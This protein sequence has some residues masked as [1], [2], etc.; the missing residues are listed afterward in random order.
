MKLK[1]EKEFNDKY[2][3]ETYVKGD[4]VEF[5]DS[6]AEEILADDRELASEFKEKP[7]K[8]IKK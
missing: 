2:T 4:V 5:E 7:T 1:I 6:R 8:K 3:G